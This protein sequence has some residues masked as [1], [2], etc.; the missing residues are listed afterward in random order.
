MNPYY[1]DYFWKEGLP[2]GIEQM[3]SPEDITYKVVMDP[4]KKRISIEKYSWGDFLEL[5]YDSALF[6]FRSLK[7]ENQFAWEKTRV[8]DS[9]VS[10]IRDQN[11]RV[12][13]KEEYEFEGERC[14]KCSI[15]SPHGILIGIQRM[16]YHGL[17]DS[18]N[19][20]ELRD[21]NDHQVMRKE[22]EM[23]QVLDEFGQL[24][25]ELWDFSKIVD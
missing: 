11:D 7:G 20:V 22:Y 4:Y 6:D 12:I 8:R 1:R 16:Y 23:N 3:P 2:Y 9:S 18:F 13:L 17:N 15:Y 25:K 19:G 10:I 5:V 21:A 24:T 14:R